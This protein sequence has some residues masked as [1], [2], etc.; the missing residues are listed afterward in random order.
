MSKENKRSKMLGE[1]EIGKLTFPRLELIHA[2][3]E[4]SLSTLAINILF[5]IFISICILL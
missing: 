5:I 3:C 1:E 4:C 2:L